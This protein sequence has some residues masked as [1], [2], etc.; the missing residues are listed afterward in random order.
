[1]TVDNK[2]VWEQAYERFY[3][4]GV[5]PLFAPEAAL[6]EPLLRDGPEVVH[7]QSGNGD[8]DIQLVRAGA[9]RVIGVDYSFRATAL[10]QRQA[11]KHGTNCSYVVG[12]VPGVPLRDGCADL[13]YTGKGALIWQP[14]IDAWARDAAR[15]LRP[16]GHLFLYE[17]HPI[18]PL[19]TKDADE[20]RI[21]ADRGY[22]DR[23]YTCD[24]WP[25]VGATS[26]LW[27]L[28]ELVTAVI[29]AGLAVR[30]LAEYA[31]PFWK[32]DDVEAAAWTGRL[33]NSFSL[34]CRSAR[35]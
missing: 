22:F 28:G 34:L 26:W 23:S 3:E 29:G 25:G 11:D 21:R 24:T 10:A 9:A 7:L 16:G 5:H 14:D 12:S 6:L 35:L 4:D 32:E 17:E 1:M 13:V 19:W 15:L 27:T 18:N 33:P 8:D 30:H 31:E 20:A 2:S